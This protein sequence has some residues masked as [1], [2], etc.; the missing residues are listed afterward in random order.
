MGSF[1]VL[2]LLPSSECFD[3]SSVSD[4]ELNSSPGSNIAVSVIFLLAT[5][6]ASLNGCLWALVFEST[7]SSFKLLTFETKIEGPNDSFT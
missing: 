3:S 1:L 6:L 4:S 2:V 7:F 5:F